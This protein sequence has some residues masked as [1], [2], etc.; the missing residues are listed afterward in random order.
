MLAK[1]LAEEQGGSLS[2][3]GAE[4]GNPG[5]EIRLGLPL[6]DPAAFLPG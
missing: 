6:A 4:A 2:V 5:C 3:R 1:M